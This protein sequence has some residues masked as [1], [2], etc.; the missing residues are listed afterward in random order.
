M[1]GDRILQGI[2]L[3]YVR[4]TTDHRVVI[5]KWTCSS[6]F[7]FPQMLFPYFFLNISKLNTKVE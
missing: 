2:F 1:N 3:M 5:M 6:I 4:S 7:F